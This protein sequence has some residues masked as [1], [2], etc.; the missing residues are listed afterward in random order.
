M[1]IFMK[2]V[3]AVLAAFCLLSFAYA[4]QTTVNV[5]LIEGKTEANASEI[6]D[7]VGLFA[8]FQRCFSDIERFLIIPNSQDPRAGLDF[9]EGEKVRADVSLGPYPIL[10][11]I[12]ENDA[13]HELQSKNLIYKPIAGQN[14]SVPEGYI[15]DQDPKNASCIGPNFKI[16]IF[17]NTPVIIEEPY[18]NKRVGSAATVRGSLS[19]DLKNNEHLWIAVKPQKS[20]KDWWPQTGGDIKL[21]NR[22]FEANAF[23]GGIK[24][25]TFEIGVL[26]VDDE[27]NKKFLDWLKL[28][29]SKNDWP[30]ITQ[31]YPGTDIKVSKEEIEEHKIAKINVILDE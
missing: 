22:E 17:V 1:S 12:S 9:F 4:E 28:S 19:S 11:G 2:I 15:F 23:L 7:N 27:I 13:L 8:E 5:P 20:I 6:L 25:D 29:Q 14:N 31:G 3:L 30:P 26:L 10:I 24:N 18:E 21:I 16:K